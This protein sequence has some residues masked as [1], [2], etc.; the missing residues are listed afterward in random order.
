MVLTHSDKD[1]HLHT[2]ILV[3]INI[4]CTLSIAADKEN[5][6][7][8][9]LIIHEDMEE[10]RSTKADEDQEANRLTSEEMEEIQVISI[11]YTLKM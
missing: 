6:G 11:L 2:I 8:G 1:K 3:R 5:Y 10:L 9:M 4:W 7:Q